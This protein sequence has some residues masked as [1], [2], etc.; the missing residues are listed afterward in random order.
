[1]VGAGV[2]VCMDEASETRLMV[3]AVRPMRMCLPV[4]LVVTLHVI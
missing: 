1:V 4:S 2:V 3:V